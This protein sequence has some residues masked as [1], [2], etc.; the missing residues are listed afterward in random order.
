MAPSRPQGKL[1]ADE[2]A[3]T[4]AQ[5]FRETKAL[6]HLDISK[7]E[8]TASSCKLLAEGLTENKTILGMHVVGNEATVTHDG[9]LVP[10]KA[11]DT[12]AGAAAPGAA[13]GGA[14]AGAHGDAGR[15]YRACFIDICGSPEKSGISA[16]SSQGIARSCP[17]GSA[18]P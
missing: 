5:L 10:M 18:G 12:S 13:L 11:V 15:P 14:A 3:S 2:S 7:C 4:L 9:F 8:L 1:C 17:E 6:V 16:P